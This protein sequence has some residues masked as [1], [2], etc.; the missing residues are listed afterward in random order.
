MQI[1]WIAQT[2]SPAEFERIRRLE[3]KRLASSCPSGALQLRLEKMA[4][5]Y[6][7]CVP[8]HVRI[9]L[10][11]MQPNRG[12]RQRDTKSKRFPTWRCPMQCFTRRQSPIEFW[13]RTIAQLTGVV[14]WWY[15]KNLVAGNFLMR[16]ILILLALNILRTINNGRMPVMFLRAVDCDVPL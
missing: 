11:L 6:S 2:Y 16:F 13:R 7:S 1:S 5:K 15:P 9:M 12:T 10:H 14:E 4:W 3:S 8:D